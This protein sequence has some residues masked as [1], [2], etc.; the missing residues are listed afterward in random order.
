MI[1]VFVERRNDFVLL[2]APAG[3]AWCEAAE[4]LGFRTVCIGG[5]ELANSDGQWLEAYGL[6]E[7]GA[8]LVRP[9]G[10]VGWRSRAMPAHPA[11]TLGEAMTSILGRA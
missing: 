1:F 9:D 3:K 7:T 5:G 10:Y 8:V 11:A 6:D 2:T 4:R